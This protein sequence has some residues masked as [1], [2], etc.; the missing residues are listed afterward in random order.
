M[1]VFAPSVGGWGAQWEEPLSLSS[2]A[3]SLPITIAAP[4]LQ[5]P[6]GKRWFYFD[7]SLGAGRFIFELCLV[8]EKKNL[9]ALS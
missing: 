7:P 6:F 3:T 2:P 4:A 8:W 9:S 5:G 1:V